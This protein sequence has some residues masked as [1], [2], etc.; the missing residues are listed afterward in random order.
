MKVVLIAFLLFIVRIG[1]FAQSTIV[2]DPERS[3]SVDTNSVGG[4]RI[5]AVGNTLHLFW[6]PSPLQGDYMIYVRS[7]DAGLTWSQP[8][9]VWADTLTNSG[10]TDRIAVSGPHLYLFWVTCDT[11]DGQPNHYLVTFRK[12]SNG[13]TT[14]EP[15]VRLFPRNTGF[16]T[17][18]DSVVVRLYFTSQISNL[19]VS[20][21]FGISWETKPFAL[22]NFQKAVLDDSHILHMIQPAVGT[23]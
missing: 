17:T 8:R 23:P 6:Q 19:Q 20:T 13:G 9:N 16:I 22:R 21:D 18:S 12:T 3:M 15:Y 5:F 7:V 11:C 10:S 14:F 2:W 1:S 4:T